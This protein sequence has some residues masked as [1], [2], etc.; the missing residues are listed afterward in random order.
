MGPL[1]AAAAARAGN[2][3]KAAFSSWHLYILTRAERSSEICCG[4]PFTGYFCTLQPAGGRKRRRGEAG[5]ISFPTAP[6]HPCPPSREVAAV[7]AR[8]P[9]SPGV[10]E[11]SSASGCSFHYELEP[12]GV[13]P[14]TGETRFALRWESES[15][16]ACPGEAQERSGDGLEINQPRRRERPSRKVAERKQAWEVGREISQ[17]AVPRN[18]SLNL[19]FTWTSRPAPDLPRCPVSPPVLGGNPASRVP[20][21]RDGGTCPAHLRCCTGSIVGGSC[22]ARHRL[23]PGPAQA[24]AAIPWR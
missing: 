20:A 5:P 16:A 12:G 18:Q 22:R 15:P 24:G 23:E 7:P 14:C 3:Q 2:L 8:G 17:A 21:S 13:F 6:Q 4:L 10:M 19:Q 9:T 11:S 1:S